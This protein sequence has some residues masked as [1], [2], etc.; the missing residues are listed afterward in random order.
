MSDM[1]SQ[2]EIEALLSMGNSEPPVPSP[3]SEGASAD[4]DTQA[5]ITDT[6]KDTL[7][8]VGNICM[9]T[10]ATTMYTLLGHR[11]DITTPRVSVYRPED[12][13]REYAAPYIAVEVQYTEGVL[14][15]NLLLLR[16]YDAAVITDLMMGGDGKVE[17]PIELSEL[18]LSAISE[19]MNQ[20][21]GS[22]ATS[23]SEMLHSV[24]NISPPTAQLVDLAA[25]PHIDT[26]DNID[27]IIKISFQ[28][29]I[30]GLLNSEL[31]QIMPLSF[32]KQLV[33]RL[34]EGPTDDSPPLIPPP[35]PPPPPPAPAP[36]SAPPPP[37][38]PAMDF[39]AAAPEYGAPAGYGAP[40]GYGAPAGGMPPGYGAP[41]PGYGYPQQPPPGGMPPP[42]YGYAPPPPSVNVQPV[43]YQ[44]FD[45]PASPP[46]G[47]NIGLI[48]DVPLQV[49][50]ELG[51]AKKSI[52]EVLE[53]GVGSIIV[54][55]K[56]A[57][58][59]V[60]VM[61]NGKLIAKGE[62]VVID[63]NYGVRINEII[64]PDKRV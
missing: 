23:L 57:G 10:A 25:T 32:G 55:D 61:V 1:M 14:G 8:E 64:S 24:V 54:L 37:P 18:H 17:M 62:V 5:L 53:F 12:L 4:L 27:V 33:Q 21:V 38:P 7:G 30:E 19:V 39:G 15:N 6:E 9:G 2:E 46:G 51:K 20:M 45:Y 29:E 31:M 59:M 49:T 47:Q 44:Q 28:M 43:Q 63:E 42:G 50:V 22:S 40:T 41:P 48:I 13:L 3:A 34:I 16:E 60:D 56:L 58:D 35:A 11:V 52:K 26:L 36:V